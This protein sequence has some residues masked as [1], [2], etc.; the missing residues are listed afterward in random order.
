MKKIQRKFSKRIYL[1]ALIFALSIFLLG[2]SVGNIFTGYM[3]YKFDDNKDLLEIQLTSLNLKDEIVS[4][5]EEFCKFGVENIL[6]DKYDLGAKISMLEQ[7]KGKND[8]E[9]LIQKEIYQLIEIKTLLLLNN[10]KEKCKD[11][12]VTILFFYTNDENDPKGSSD[13]SEYQGYILS[14]Y[15]RL[16]PK[17]YVVFSFDINSRSD[18]V[19]TLIDLHDIQY[20]PITIIGKNRYTDYNDL[21][22]LTEL[23]NNRT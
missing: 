23:I 11:D 3:T 7:K 22:R 2:I 19:K 9:V 13:Q 8:K 1:I 16:Y 20:V 21:D 15:Y 10:F 18:A 6:K 14:N 12:K 4:S 5:S 17:N